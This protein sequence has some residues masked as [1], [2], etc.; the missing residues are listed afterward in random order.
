MKRITVLLPFALVAAGCVYPAQSMS[1]ASWGPGMYARP[2]GPQVR[3]ATLPYGRWDNVMMTAVGTPLFVLMMDGRTASGD[4]VAASIDNVRLHVASGE[5]DLAARD[6]MRVDR[7]SGTRD[8][9]QDGARAAAYGAAVVG[10]LGLIVG[11]VPPARLFA[12]GGIIGASQ[13][14]QASLDARGAT[15][16]YLARGIVPPGPG[17]ISPPA[18]LSAPRMGPSGPCG[19][20]GSSCNTDIRYSRMGSPGRR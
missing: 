9:A 13:G 1:G 12:A 20:G 3:L 17:P 4:V 5:V 15:T 16:I 8:V 14:V 18:N 2:Y 10:V 19:H 11:H 7:V 6:V